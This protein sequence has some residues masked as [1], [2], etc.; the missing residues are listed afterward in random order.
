LPGE[1]QVTV[2]L[3]KVL[4]GT[5]LDVTQ[6]GIPDAIPPEACCLG[7]REPPRNLARVSSSPRS[8]SRRRHKQ[9][10]AGA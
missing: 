9:G 2:A 7:W 6:A 8:T 3:K 5:E 1:I 10:L 4:V